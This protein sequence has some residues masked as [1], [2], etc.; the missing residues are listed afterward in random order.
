MDLARLS[1]SSHGHVARASTVWCEST[2]HGQDGSHVPIDQVTK[3]NMII[4]FRSD[5]T[6]SLTRMLPENVIKQ[7]IRTNCECE[8]SMSIPV[9][10]DRRCC[11]LCRRL[12]VGRPME[13]GHLAAAGCTRPRQSCPC[14]RSHRRRGS[15]GPHTGGPIGRRTDRGRTLP[16]TRHTVPHTD[17]RPAGHHRCAERPAPHATGSEHSRHQLQHAHQLPAEN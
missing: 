17:C 5:K 11:F 16:G 4:K 10:G 7:Y 13:V 2:V 15:G 12:A 14:S 9:I 6:P 1:L 3:E 8:G